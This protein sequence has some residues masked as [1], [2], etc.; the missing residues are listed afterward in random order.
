MCYS[1]HYWLKYGN[2]IP[3]LHISFKHT[4][5]RMKVTSPL[6]YFTPKW[7]LILLFYLLHTSKFTLEIMNIKSCNSINRRVIISYNSITSNI[8]GK[9]IPPTTNNTFNKHKKKELDP[10][11]CV[12]FH[13]CQ[14]APRSSVEWELNIITFDGK[15]FFLLTPR[16]HL[17]AHWFP[18][19]LYMDVNWGSAFSP[20]ML[21]FI[22]P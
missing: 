15:L 3:K 6:H 13:L 11:Q 19:N 4:Y 22:L 14:K 9:F 10:T 8:K 21:P 18:K 16:E 2:L 5:R 1:I 17:Y 7:K 20:Y 12:H